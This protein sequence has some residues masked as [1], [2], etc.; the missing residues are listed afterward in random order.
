MTNKWDLDAQI[1]LFNLIYNLLSSLISACLGKL[2]G[3]DT[4][5]GRKLEV[6]D[7][8]QHGEPIYVMLSCANTLNKFYSTP[9]VPNK[10]NL[11]MFMTEV[12]YT[13]YRPTNVCHR[14]VF[15]EDCQFR[16]LDIILFIQRANIHRD[17]DMWNYCISSICC[18]IITDYS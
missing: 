15:F 16:V 8:I 5:V 10:R 1:I 11:I 9:A 4:L 3:L 7:D 18:E 12:W 13:V 14:K 17:N 6:K 2:S